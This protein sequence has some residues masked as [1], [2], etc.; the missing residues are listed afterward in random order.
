MLFTSNLKFLSSMNLSVIPQSK[1]GCFSLGLPSV[2]PI[3]TGSLLTPG[4]L[5]VIATA[6]TYTASFMASTA[7][8]VVPCVISAWLFTTFSV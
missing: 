7:I 5:S 2:G 4:L 6:M 1:V 3:L 8:C